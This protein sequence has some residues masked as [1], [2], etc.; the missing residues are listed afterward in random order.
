MSCTITNQRPHFKPQEIMAFMEWKEFCRTAPTRRHVGII[1]LYYVLQSWTQK[2]CTQL[3]SCNR[4]HF[5]LPAKSP[6]TETVIYCNDW[7]IRISNGM[8]DNL[9]W[10]VVIL[11]KRRKGSDCNWQEHLCY[12][13]CRINVS[14]A[15]QYRWLS[16]RLQYIQCASNG[17]TAVLH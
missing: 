10:T 12:L 6:C 14:L 9:I 13:L 15:S 5:K 17:D 2:G 1:S 4:V 16:A 3:C 11:K 7:T 8:G